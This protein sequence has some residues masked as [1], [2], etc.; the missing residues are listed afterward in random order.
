MNTHKYMTI[1]GEM[2]PIEGERN[3]L[4]VIRKAG[5]ELPTFC[6]HSE[7]S[8]YGACRMCI[9]E[10]EKGNIMTSCSTP[11][12]EGMVIK[13]NTTRLYKYRR[14]IIRMLLSSHCRECT[15]CSKNGEC[16]LQSLAKRFGID[17][18]RFD[19]SEK[20]WK[21]EYPIDRSSKSIIKN[22]NKCIHCGDCVRMCAEVQNVGA[23]DFA[24]RGWNL[25]VTP[26]FN[27]PLADTDCVG[28]GQCVAV[29]PTG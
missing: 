25:E 19:K 15:T 18:I 11:P 4:E 5:I 2:T 29:C 20:A 27:D 24:N 12:K 7:L 26:A 14:Q 28:C 17:E 22:P 21:D 16:V 6:Y 23:I 8:I 10:D 1:N 13:T 3:I 9:V